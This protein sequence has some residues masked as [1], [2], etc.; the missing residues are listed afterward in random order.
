M[1]P[2][3]KLR[4]VYGV[5]TRATVDRI[6]RT[7]GLA[8]GETRTAGAAWYSGT[9]DELAAESGKPR[10]TV[11]A[12]LAHLSP[13]TMWALNVAG[14]RAM[15]NGTELP[16]GLIGDNVARARVA[17]ESATPLETFGPAAA[18]TRRFAHNLLGDR[19]L[20]TVD[21]WALRV[22]LGDRADERGLK[23]VGVYDALE[24]CYRL[25]ARRLGTDPVTV[26]ATTWIVARNGRAA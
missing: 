21:V 16:A 11:A 14:A 25:A 12:V 9:V 8:D 6:V 26:Q 15:L 7:Y 24:H 3:A 10:E 17:L 19:E 1:S 13:R 4:T 20:V 5:G 22:A 23:R 2:D 18:K